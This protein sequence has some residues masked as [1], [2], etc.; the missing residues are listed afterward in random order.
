MNAK[1]P[2]PM[3]NR[4]PTSE[5]YAE[6]AESA[7]RAE[8]WPQ[9][10]ALWRQVASLETDETRRERYWREAERCDAEV[11]LDKRLAE[12]ARRILGIPTLDLRKADRLDFHEVGVHNLLQALRLA[13]RAGQEAPAG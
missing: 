11:E 12:I 5:D 4:P 7:F 1:E 13:Y 6:E 3:T 9:A 2:L 10:A 8:A